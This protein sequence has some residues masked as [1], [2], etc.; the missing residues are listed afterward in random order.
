MEQERGWGAQ[1][2]GCYAQVRRESFGV[3]LYLCHL[4]SDGLGA[5]IELQPTQYWSSPRLAGDRVCSWDTRERWLP[6][7]FVWRPEL[8]I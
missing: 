2:A 8:Q 4:T 1:P 5:L 3:F 6:R 7:V